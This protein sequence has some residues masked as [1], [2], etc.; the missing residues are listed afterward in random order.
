[1]A[2][3]E[4]ESRKWTCPWCGRVASRPTEHR[5]ICYSRTCDCGAVA[6]GAPPWDSDE[7]IDD[8]IGIFQVEVRPES[9]GYDALLLEDIK[10]SGVEV[11]E[12]VLETGVPGMPHGW[13][14][15]YLWFR[16]TPSDRSEA[17]Y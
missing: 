1:M 9:R 12:G 16:R 4:G 14:V 3:A 15:R 11:R 2:N 7:I 8:A 10:R 6:L 13:K 5:L 17:D